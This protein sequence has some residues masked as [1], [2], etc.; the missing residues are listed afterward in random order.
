MDS[1]ISFFNQQP[2]YLHIYYVLLLVSSV[3]FLLLKGLP[4]NKAVK[5][6]PFYRLFDWNKYDVS[7]TVQRNKLY[8]I[9][10]VQFSIFG[11]A[12]ELIFGNLLEGIALWVLVVMVAMLLLF[13]S[14]RLVKRKMIKQSD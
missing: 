14:V 7:E 13:G 12:F 1:I 11:I 9:R 10:L 4:D 2:D 3:R 5:I 8:S 6:L